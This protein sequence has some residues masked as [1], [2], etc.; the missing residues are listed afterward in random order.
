MNSIEPLHDNT[1]PLNGCGTDERSRQTIHSAFLHAEEAHDQPDVS[2]APSNDPA[3]E[4]HLLPL[5]AREDDPEL[6]LDNPSY[7]QTED[8]VADESWSHA[9]D[10]LDFHLWTSYINDPLQASDT[11]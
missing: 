6:G 9:L 4:K 2:S 10:D 11:Q 7:D 1:A 8:N 3:M 5:P